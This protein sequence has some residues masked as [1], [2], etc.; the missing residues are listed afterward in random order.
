MKVIR[1]CFSWL[2]SFDKLI[3]FRKVIFTLLVF[4]AAFYFHAWSG[5]HSDQLL[6][7]GAVS[8]AGSSETKA[9]PQTSF[10]INTASSKELI[11]LPGIGPKLAEVIL[12]DREQHGPFLQLS[13]LLRV[14]GIGPKKLKDMAPFLRFDPPTK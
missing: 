10:N 14:R 13:D 5:Q 3:V 11:S 9:T 4:S 1:F 12:N 6:F 8:E 2:V 7:S